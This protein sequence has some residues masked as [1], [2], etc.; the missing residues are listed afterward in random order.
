MPEVPRPASGGWKKSLIAAAGG[1]VIGALAVGLYYGLKE[2][3]RA[4]T[5]KIVRDYILDHGEILPEAMNRL[6]QRQVSTAV[7]QNRAALER[8]FHSAWAGAA[9]G[10]VVL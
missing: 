3:G 2:P 9:D 10:D 4:G 1:L 5:E 6:Q 8:P 7:G